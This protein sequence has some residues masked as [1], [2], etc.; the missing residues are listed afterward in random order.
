MA[1]AA[2]FFELNGCILEFTE[3][4]A[5]RITIGIDRGEVSFVEVVSWLKE[6]IRAV[7]DIE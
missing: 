5:I 2:T 4:E 1:A 6:H 3:K 7:E